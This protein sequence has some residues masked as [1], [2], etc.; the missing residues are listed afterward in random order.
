MASVASAARNVLLYLT[1]NDDRSF[2]VDMLNFHHMRRHAPGVARLEVV[3]VIS[4]VRPAT[5]ADQRAIDWLIADCA[6]CPWLAVRAAIWKG[7]VGRDFSSAAVGLRALAQELA[8]DDRVMV[9][10]R[11]GYGPFAPDWYRRYVDQLQRHPGTTLTGSTLCLRGHPK[12]ASEAP[13][14]H[15]QSYVYLSLWRYLR[16]LTGR[17]PGARCVER[18]RVI[19]EG[20]IG[21]SRQ[22]LLQGARISCLHWPELAVDAELASCSDLPREDFKNRDLGLPIRYKFKAYRRRLR[23]LGLHGRWLLRRLGAVH[24]AP[25]ALAPLHQFCSD[26]DAVAESSSRQESLEQ[27]WSSAARQR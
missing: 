15:V 20:E 25:P 19:V 13:W 18:T 10:N 1:A 27:V 8:L 12:L 22:F 5:A 16:P 4:C 2:A 26:Y 24:L 23:D 17:F 3:I 11:S 6:D 9:R 14:A 7:N 21:L